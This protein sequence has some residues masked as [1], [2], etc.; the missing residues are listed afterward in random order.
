MDIRRCTVRMCFK[1]PFRNIPEGAEL[2]KAVLLLISLFFTSVVE[3]TEEKS[4]LF[5]LL[6]FRCY[7]E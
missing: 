6:V 2:N 7:I 1:L 3:E 5:G 4:Y